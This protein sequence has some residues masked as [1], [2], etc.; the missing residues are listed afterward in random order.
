MNDSNSTTTSILTYTTDKENFAENS[1]K[2]ILNWCLLIIVLMAIILNSFICLAICRNYKPQRCGLRQT[3]FSFSFSH[4]IYSTM[5]GSLTLYQTIYLAD[6]SPWACKLWQT[7]ENWSMTLIITHIFFIIMEVTLAVVNPM[8]RQRLQENFKMAIL[9]TWLIA[10]LFVIPPLIFNLLAKS[11][12]IEFVEC[13]LVTSTYAFLKPIFVYC[14]PCV[15]SFCLL[16]Y[17]SCCVEKQ[18]QIG[19]E[20]CSENSPLQTNGHLP[21]SVTMVRTAGDT[22]AITTQPATPDSDTNKPFSLACEVKD[23]KVI[24]PSTKENSVENSINNNQQQNSEN[25]NN[26]CSEVN[27]AESSKND[28]VDNNKVETNLPDT[29]VSDNAKNLEQS[30]TS[31]KVTEEMEIICKE[32]KIQHRNET[33]IAEN[34][35]VETSNSMYNENQPDFE[36]NKESKE[37]NESLVESESNLE[38]NKESTEPGECH[39]ENE[40]IKNTSPTLLVT[41]SSVKKKDDDKTADNKTSFHEV[42]SKSVSEDDPNFDITDYVSDRKSGKHQLNAKRRSLERQNLVC[43]DDLVVGIDNPVFDN[44]L[45]EEIRVKDHPERSIS[46]D[47]QPSKRENVRKSISLDEIILEKEPKLRPRP[48]ILSRDG[49]RRQGRSRKSVKFGQNEM[50][51]YNVKSGAMS[52]V[53]PEHELKNENTL[54]RKNTPRYPRRNSSLQRQNALENGE[55][56]KSNGNAKSLKPMSYMRQ[57]SQEQGTKL[58]QKTRQNSAILR[59][60]KYFLISSVFLTIPFLIVELGCGVSQQFRDETSTQTILAF[61]WTFISSSII[62]PMIIYTLNADVRKAFKVTCCSK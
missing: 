52:P 51:T 23:K 49:K 39:N 27:S 18:R 44:S 40:T 38:D 20:L 55:L 4:V 59:L 46:M 50:R 33:Y 41:A 47:G 5:A 35:T 43:E 36:Q 3:L 12:S 19:E 13:L 6:M 57:V 7:A 11:S 25:R 53:F 21:T 10:F 22:I 48:S 9:I 60:A 8:I 17:A 1:E 2:N 29:S 28:K 32:A 14:L 42:F 54:R 26:I 34:E 61:K 56:S 37:S 16:F 30:E 62:H 24:E 15:L 31:G 45:A 58:L